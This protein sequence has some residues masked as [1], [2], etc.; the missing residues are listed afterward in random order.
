[1]V[2]LEMIRPEVKD[3]MTKMEP[4]FFN[5]P[6]VVPRV[7]DH[8][9]PLLDLQTFAVTHTV[10]AYLRATLHRTQATTSSDALFFTKHRNTPEHRAEARLVR[11]RQCSSI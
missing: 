10:T 7:T 2:N 8:V 3:R 1:M 9:H 11:T 4:P 5:L 6:H